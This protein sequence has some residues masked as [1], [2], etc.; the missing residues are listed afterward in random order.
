MDPV[1]PPTALPDDVV[2]AR[3]ALQAADQLLVRA[4]GGNGIAPSDTSRGMPHLSP[5]A[6]EAYRF[7]LLQETEGLLDLIV[8]LAIAA[9][10]RITP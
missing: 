9:G 8:H 4:Y 6:R 2:L 3:R 10:R 1:S 7:L 5:M